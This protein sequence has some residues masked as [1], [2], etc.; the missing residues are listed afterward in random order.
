V[1][2]PEC[3][4]DNTGASIPGGYSGVVVTTWNTSSDHSTKDYKVY[5]AVLDKYAKGSSKGGTAPG[6][7]MAVR[8]FADA[9]SK[10]TGDINAAS[11][12]STFS[13]MP[14]PVA[15]P[16]GGG[17]T[18]QCGTKPVA[19]APNICASTVLQGKLDKQGNGSNF[20]VLETSDLTQIG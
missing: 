4:G 19:I 7:Y 11:V 14:S 2:N 3:I 5:S 18:F 20:K 1:I 15:F 9:M 12:L 16:M 8:S 13:A 6:G 17:T 10:A